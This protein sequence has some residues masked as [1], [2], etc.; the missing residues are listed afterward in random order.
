MQIPDRFGHKIIRTYGERGS[1]WLAALP[2]ILARCIQKWQLSDCE[3]SGILSYN[4]ILFAT[5]PHFGQVALK[6]G[7]DL[8]PEMQ[9]L[10]LYRGR[11][12]CQCYDSDEALGA[13]L[14]E[15]VMPGYDLTTVTDNTE[16][17]HI[18]AQVVS[19]LPLSMDTTSHN[20]K[21][22]SQ[23]LE[24]AFSRARSE[25]KV[26]AE[27]LQ[28]IEIADQLYSDI[29]RPEQAQVLLHGDLNHWNILQDK[30]GTWKA[31]DPQGVIGVHCLESARFIENQRDMVPLAERIGH[32][33]EM[34]TIFG[35]TL[36]ETKKAI[37]CA[38]FVDTILSTCWTY[39]EDT[40]QDKLAECVQKCALTWEYVRQLL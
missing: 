24:R 7:L 16:R 39:E 2:D 9:A 30:S 5:S 8:R 26:G 21:T 37:A 25:G 28:Y 27:M 18:A 13:M 6:V 36:G 11:H 31:I 35:T 4:F 10:D 22:Y 3:T 38:L 33:D 17:I 19:R 20:L 29:N 32:I 23:W 1:S 40:P 34:V 12:I 14:L 15:R